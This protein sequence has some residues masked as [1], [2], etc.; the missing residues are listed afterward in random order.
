MHCKKIYIGKKNKYKC[1]SHW[2]ISYYL[3]ST[4]HNEW[5]RWVLE[6]NTKTNLIECLSSSSRDKYKNTLKNPTHGTSLVVQWLRVCLAMQGTWAWALVG[7]LRY[8]VPWGNEA[9]MLQILTHAHS[10]AWVPQLKSVCT[11][12]DPARRKEEDLTC[13]N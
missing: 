1:R 5:F 4:M 11:R 13:Y 12:T 6:N 7:E 10:R 8:H 9:H 2:F 3:V